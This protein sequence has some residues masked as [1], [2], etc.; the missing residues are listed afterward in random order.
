MSVRIWLGLFVV[1]VLL[2]AGRWLPGW[3][4]FG[5]R[6][7]ASLPVC[8]FGCWLIVR[9]A[10]RSM[11]QRH[12]RRTRL[13]ER[14][15]RMWNDGRAWWWNRLLTNEEIMKLANG[16]DPRSIPGCKDAGTAER[17]KTATFPAVPTNEH[18]EAIVDRLVA[19]RTAEH[20][21]GEKESP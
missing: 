16:A 5:W 17:A 19:R 4:P 11:R 7:F 8:A 2:A 21:K 15:I 14:W 9:G 20:A 3:E 1:F 10:H 12:D 6:D 13:A 18:D